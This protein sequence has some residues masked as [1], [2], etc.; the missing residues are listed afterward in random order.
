LLGNPYD[1]SAHQRAFVLT[2][3]NPR[4]VGWKCLQQ[5][6]GTM[7]RHYP[8]IGPWCGVDMQLAVLGGI[9]FSTNDMIATNSIDFERQHRHDLDPWPC[10]WP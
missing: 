2:D 7:R 9:I 4:R 5:R 10:C 1:G 6:H 3:W 8:D